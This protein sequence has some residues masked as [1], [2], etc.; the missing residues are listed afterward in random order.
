MNT[1][2]LHTLTVEQPIGKFYVTKISYSDL[3]VMSKVDRRHI[4]EDDEVLGIQRELKNDKVNQIKKYLTTVFATFPNS[5]IV[6]VSSSNI[7]NQTDD[8][9][10]LKVND[11]TFTIIDGQHRLAGFDNYKGGNFELVLSIF[12]DMDI[13]QQADIF[14]TI[15]S[16]QTKVD[17]SLNVNLELDSKYYTPRKMMVEIAQSFNYAKE[18]PWFNSIKMLGGGKGGFISLSSFARPLFGLTYRESDWYIIK[19]RLIIGEENNS[20]SEISYD[21]SKYL[22]WDFYKHRDSA[23]VYKILN[24]F[25]SA[26][27]DIF[28]TDWMNEKSILNKTTGYNAMMRLFK[29]FIP[30]GLDEKRFTYD[31]FIEKMTPLSKLD[32]SIRSENY[33]SSGLYSTNQ[34]YKDFIDALAGAGILLSKVQENVS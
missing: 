24:N 4:T 21:A 26:L 19:N 7:A 34:L 13:S 27:K 22:F 30:V 25:F 18:S 9:L 12:I 11:D 5:I 31:F 29:E 20:F 8:V 17:P 3:W 14:S 16:E 2:D 10:T 32:G 6:N 23:S 15:N 33:G 28:P 1:I